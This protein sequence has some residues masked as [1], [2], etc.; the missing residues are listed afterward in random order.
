M[1]AS[2]VSGNPSNTAWAI[3]VAIAV[4]SSSAGA[5]PVPE[6]FPGATLPDVTRVQDKLGSRSGVVDIA[7][8]NTVVANPTGIVVGGKT[9]V[10][11]ANG[12]VDPAALEG[13]SAGNS[14]PSLTAALPVSSPPD[15]STSP[16]VMLGVDRSLTYK[17][18]F[19]LIYSLRKHGRFQ[20]LVMAGGAI[21]AIPIELPT[22]PIKDDLRMVVSASK[23]EVRVWSLSGKE[24]TAKK[25]L[26]RV[27][28]DDK[29]DDV[30]RGNAAMQVRTTLEAVA[31]RWSG[32]KKVT[33]GKTLVVM[34][35]GGLSMQF[36]ADLIVAARAQFP[37][38]ALSAGFE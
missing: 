15:G 33:F 24:G 8:G 25:P 4:M 16:P 5:K 9:L 31:K 7:T 36:V 27:A 11:I 3:I 35:D 29:A 28:L 26:L 32:K 22:K 38:I 21:A 12:A 13:G 34:A 10:P 1:C 37:N 17:V 6:K 20:V 2:I 30:A 19:A 23:T 18:L 14:I